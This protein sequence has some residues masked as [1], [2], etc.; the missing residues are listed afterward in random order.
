M[1][2][3]ARSPLRTMSYDELQMRTGLSK[4]TLRRLVAAR[5]VPHIKLSAYA[6]RFDRE[7]IERWI[8]S[9]TV[10]PQAKEQTP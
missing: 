6:V 10:K 5:Q 1:T 8:E 4:R 2:S 3:E 7:E 9:R